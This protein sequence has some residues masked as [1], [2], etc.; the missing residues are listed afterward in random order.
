[1]R[2][3]STTTNDEKKKL[4]HPTEDECQEKLRMLSN[5]DEIT[6]SC[7]MFLDMIDENEKEA[8]GNSKYVRGGRKSSFG[9]SQAA[10]QRRFTGK[11]SGDS[12]SAA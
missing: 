6:P 8:G 3:S 2:S 12:L 5:R 4:Q 1:M 11:M 7:K 9:L 10:L